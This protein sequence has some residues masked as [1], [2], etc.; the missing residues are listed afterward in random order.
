MSLRPGETC[1][2]NLKN[3]QRWFC[4]YGHIMDFLLPFETLFD[5]DQCVI[6]SADE[7]VASDMKQFKVLAEQPNTGEGREK[8]SASR[9][10]VRRFGRRSPIQTIYRP[11]ESL[12]AEESQRSLRMRTS[13][14]QHAAGSTRTS[15]RLFT[16]VPVVSNPS[17]VSRRYERTVL[18]DVAAGLTPRS[19][20]PERPE[21]NPFS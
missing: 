16:I 10:S 9:Q 15:L 11:S 2:F 17:F 7:A 18:H 19:Q 12:E 20:F 21:C 8:V 5:R 13:V 14:L 6:F 1:G 4:D 3:A